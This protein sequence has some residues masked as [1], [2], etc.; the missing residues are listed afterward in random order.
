MTTIDPGMFYAPLLSNDI[1]V[2]A[3]SSIVK[4][5]TGKL[6]AF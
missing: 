3:A 4:M 2:I 5:I 1:V 6:S